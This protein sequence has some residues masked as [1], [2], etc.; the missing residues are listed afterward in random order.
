[1]NQAVTIIRQR[2]DASGVGEAD[3]TTEGGNNIVVQIPG[4]ADE[5]TRQRIEASAQLQLRAV[6]Y[7]GEPATTFVGEDG[8]ETPYPT[9]DPSLNSTPTAE[10][11]Q[12]QRSRLDHRSALCRVPRVRLRRPR[13]RSGERAQGRAADHVRGGRQRQV[14]PRPRRA[15][16][17]VDH[18]RHVR[19]PADQ[20]P[21]GGQ[22]Q[23][24]RRGNEDLRRDQSAP[25]RRDPAAQ[26]VRV[27]ARRLRA[28][29]PL[30]E[31]DHP[32]RRPQHH[33]KLHAG[34]RQGARRP[35][36]VRRTPAELRGG[37]LRHDLGDAG[38]AA[39]ADRPH[40]GPDRPRAGRDLR[41]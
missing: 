15:R 23:V 10:P 25:V 24:R 6:L 41:R 7:A 17:L 21:V 33:R 32:G 36:E 40:R 34:D 38:F 19:S 35:A 31:R 12:R 8:T 14:H 9:P 37:Q 39:A 27:R 22:P 1:M 11:T 30:D 26:P 4:Q 18:R 13:Q 3:V 29:G 28:V 16:R 20:R 5:Q 2:V